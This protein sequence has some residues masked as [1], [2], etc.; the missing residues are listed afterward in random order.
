MT[1]PKCSAIDYIDFLVASTRAVS[2]TEA[3]R[4]QPARPRPPAH[5]AFTRLLH[6]L[7]PDPAV[8]W[9]EVAP[10]VRRDGG[11]LV[12]DDSTLDKPYARR[13]RIS[14]WAPRS[15]IQLRKVHGSVHRVLTRVSTVS[16][17]ASAT[18]PRTTGSQVHSA[19]QCATSTRAGPPFSRN[20]A[21]GWCRRSLVRSSGGSSSRRTRRC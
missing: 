11:I 15:G 7:E 9:A 12:L 3:A 5:D 4:V 1:A 21:A 6:R 17:S 19:A 16:P 14:A 18:R 10:L 8:L 20:S 13:G 2:G